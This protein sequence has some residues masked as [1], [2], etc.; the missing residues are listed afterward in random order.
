MQ[1]YLTKADTRKGKYVCAKED[2]NVQ[3]KMQTSKKEECWWQQIGLVKRGFRLV[4]RLKAIKY[5]KR[6]LCYLSFYNLLVSDLWI[7]PDFML[8][9][10]T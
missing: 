6:L 7:D 1:Q 2:V 4:I 3:E 10:L 5:Y 9:P 8:R